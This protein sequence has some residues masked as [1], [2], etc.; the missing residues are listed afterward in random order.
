MAQRNPQTISTCLWLEVKGHI[1][2]PRR[3]VRVEAEC[4]ICQSNRLDIRG[5]KIPEGVQTEEAVVIP[6]GHLIGKDCWEAYERSRSALRNNGDPVCPVCRDNRHLPKC[7]DGCII[8]AYYLTSSKTRGDVTGWMDKVPP[9]QPAVS[10]SYACC[11]NCKHRLWYKLEKTVLDLER[12]AA[13]PG[14]PIK[15]STMLYLRELRGE[16]DRTGLVC[17]FDFSAGI[18]QNSQIFKDNVQEA[19]QLR[20]STIQSD[21]ETNPQWESEMRPIAPQ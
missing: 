12:C 7:A 19:I 21:V 2:N 10:D 5:L 13:E 9:I 3:N 1:E 11:R 17:G 15:P 20:I 8:S 14:R 16:F 4:V 18:A 6:C